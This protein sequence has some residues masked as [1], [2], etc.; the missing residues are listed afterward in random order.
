MERE[1]DWYYMLNEECNYY[2]QFLKPFL[3]DQEHNKP[4]P[5][6]AK[7]NIMEKFCHL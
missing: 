3:T 5:E 4:Q 2:L 7:E 1:G 6:V